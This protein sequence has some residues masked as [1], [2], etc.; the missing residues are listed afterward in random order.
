[1]KSESEIRQ[2]IQRWL[3]G[4]KLG[5]VFQ[6]RK[7]LDDTTKLRDIRTYIFFDLPEGLVDNGP[8][9]SGN[10]IVH[11]GARDKSRFVPAEE[12]LM[13][14]IVKFTREFERD[15]H[16]DT[17]DDR[18]NGISFIDMECTGMMGYGQDDHEYQFIFEIY[19]E[20]G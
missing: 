17:L 2:Y 9:F 20:K 19:A 1:M 10:C 18:K 3:T 14:A 12:A 6:D 4:L 5:P 8:W 7:V 13:P 11:I 15:G 16:T